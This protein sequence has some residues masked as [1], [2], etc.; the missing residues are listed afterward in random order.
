MAPAP[1]VV[2]ASPVEEVV[3]WG[4]A[5]GRECLTRPHGPVRVCREKGRFGAWW[6]GLAFV[7]GEESLGRPTAAS[8]PPVCDRKDQPP[9]WTPLS[10][11]DLLRPPRG[12]GPPAGERSAPQGWHSVDKVGEPR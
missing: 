5:G 1:G 4:G 8:Q 6:T 11:R 2:L 9:G 7:R 3:A 12:K 10:S